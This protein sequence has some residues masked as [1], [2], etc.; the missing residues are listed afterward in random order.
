MEKALPKQAI[1][2]AI[3]DAAPHTDIISK[4]DACGAE[5]LRTKEKGGAPPLRTDRRH[6]YKHLLAHV[7]LPIAWQ[8]HHPPTSSSG[9][10]AKEERKIETR[11][12]DANFCTI[13]STICT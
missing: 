5:R 9:D 13:L 4:H 12:S 2:A 8:R 6:S 7:R 3:L 10:A 11:K 1:V